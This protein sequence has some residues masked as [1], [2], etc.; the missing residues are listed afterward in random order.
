M[1]RW[2]LIIGSCGLIWILDGGGYFN[3]LKRPVSKISEPIRHYFYQLNL[4]QENQS[5]SATTEQ[6]IIEAELNKLQQE[7]VHLR[8]LLGVK[9]PARWK[10]MPAKI[11][12]LKKNSLIIDVGSEDGI[13][14]GQVVIGIKKDAVNNGIVIAR[15]KT[16]RAF[17]AEA[18][19]VTSPEVKIKVK[20]DNGA[21][22]LAQTEND[23]WQVT[24]V[25]QKFSLTKDQLMM[26]AG[27]DG[28]PAGLALGRV[29]EVIREDEAVYQKAEAISL[30]E[31]E[32]LSQVF[33]ISE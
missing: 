23:K 31:T 30:L 28:W 13:N 25:L 32:S 8:E 27:G 1:K 10:F 9:L 19:L 2:L 29:G 21:E 6:A 22:G 14:S 18:E 17:Q 3:W 12:Q 16:V 20:L 4:P 5:K 26:T 33:V 11:L 7:N 15:I 24:E